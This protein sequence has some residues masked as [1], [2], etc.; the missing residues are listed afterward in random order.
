VIVF[1]RQEGSSALQVWS[2]DGRRHAY[3]I[4]V[5]P[6]GARQ[7]QKELR[8]VLDR[9]PNAIVSPVGDKLVVEGDELSDRDRDRIS[10]LA[11]RYPQLLDFTGQ[12]GWDRMVL[13]DVQVVE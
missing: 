2:L 8:A 5:A 12:V 11:Q 1:A 4:E 13:L 7:M 3:Q 10:A 9:I 6:E